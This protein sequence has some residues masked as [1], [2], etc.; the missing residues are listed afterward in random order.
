V[1]QTINNPSRCQVAPATLSLFPPDPC[2]ESEWSG[3]SPRHINDALLAS[4]LGDH[5]AGL[6]PPADHPGRGRLVEFDTS[7]TARG[8]LRAARR[9]YHADPPHLRP[10]LR[11]PSSYVGLFTL[12]ELL[13]LVSQL[14][15]PIG[16]HPA[17][18]AKPP[19]ATNM[20][21]R[22][23]LETDG[24]LFPSSAARTADRCCDCKSN[25]KDSVTRCEFVTDG[26]SGIVPMLAFGATFARRPGLSGVL[27]SG[28]SIMTTLDFATDYVADGL[29]VIPIRPD[30]SKAPTIPWKEYQQRLPTREEL[31]QWF[32]DGRNGI[33]ILAGRVSGNLE[34]LD[35]D[36]GV[37][38]E[39]WA[40]RVRARGVDLLER[41]PRVSTPGGGS[42]LFYRLPCP[43]A[44]SRK[45]AEK[46]WTDPA[47]GKR[48]R[49]TLVETRG[50]GG[51]VV[52]PG[53]PPECHPSGRPYL[54]VPGHWLP[55]VPL[56]GEA[57][58]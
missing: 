42:H 33:A 20:A 44:G 45:L 48:M 35:F 30:G 39:Q 55:P 17:W 47:T 29:S 2:G 25:G 31:K 53:S 41:L 5:I 58:S 46:C 9:R 38:F 6:T 37:T 13:T 32:A 27:R 19:E 21:T 49:K 14:L 28:R 11:R 15:A 56:L 43:P 16:R 23:Y 8:A 4:R 3:L 12:C 51:Y 26:S 52:A 24:E 1:I 10:S 18:I 57:R 50:E 22:F 40:R 36:D 54:F 7:G 34:I